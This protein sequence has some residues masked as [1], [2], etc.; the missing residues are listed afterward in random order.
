MRLN[1]ARPIRPKPLM[2]NLVMPIS[3]PNLLQCRLRVVPH[4]AQTYR[5]PYLCGT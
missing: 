3:F 4:R 2:A 1:A 5:R